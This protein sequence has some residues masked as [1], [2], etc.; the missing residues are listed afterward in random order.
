MLHPQLRWDHP[1]ARIVWL[2]GDGLVSTCGDL[3][4][5][6]TDQA[7]QQL[8]PGSPKSLVPYRPMPPSRALFMVRLSKSR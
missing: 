5:A 1:R 8:Q 7:Q 4:P 6:V 2:L 3:R